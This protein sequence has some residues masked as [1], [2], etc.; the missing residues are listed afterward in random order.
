MAS[1]AFALITCLAQAQ[2]LTQT[3]RGNVVDKISKTSLPG[4]TVIVLNTDPIIGATTDPDG[5]FK[6]TKVPVGLHSIK[7]SFIGYKELILPNITVNSG[8]EVVLNIPIEEDMIKMDEVVV[9][10]ETS[11]EKNKPLNDL[12]VVSTRTFSVEETRKFAGAVVKRY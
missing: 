4:A 1:L 11:I 10:S 5:N 2:Q 3:I 8:K 6:L 12:S 7:I 9:S